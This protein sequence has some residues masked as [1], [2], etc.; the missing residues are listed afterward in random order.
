MAEKSNLVVYDNLLLVLGQDEKELSLVTLNL[1]GNQPCSFSSLRFIP[2][3]L[4]LPD[5]KQTENEYRYS[6]FMSGEKSDVIIKVGDQTIPAHKNILIEKSDYFAN[7][8]G[9][10]Q[11]LKFL[12][13]LSRQYV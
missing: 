4:N 6:L 9:S 11:S 13:T 8:Y 1:E 2:I 10:K 3:D 7:L 12:F 5:P